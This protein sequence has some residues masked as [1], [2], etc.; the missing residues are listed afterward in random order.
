VRPLN[1]NVIRRA[2]N[3][4]SRAFFEELHRGG[5]RYAWVLSGRKGSDADIAELAVVA[6]RG[7]RVFCQRSGSALVS[8]SWWRV[9]EWAL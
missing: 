4:F 5:D 1:C 6:S 3:P 7:P 2:T 8:A 9:T